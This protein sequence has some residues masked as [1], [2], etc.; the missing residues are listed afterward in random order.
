ML[1]AF[2]IE[3]ELVAGAYAYVVAVTHVGAGPAVVIV[4]AEPVAAEVEA[5]AGEVDG[6]VVVGRRWPWRYELPGEGWGH[7]CLQNRP[8]WQKL[9]ASTIGILILH[10]PG[11]VRRPGGPVPSSPA[12]YRRY[13]PRESGLKD[14]K[15]GGPCSQSRLAS[16]RGGRTLTSSPSSWK[17][18]RG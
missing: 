6:R 12:R 9:A 4:V 11:S 10:S 17:S 18:R 2:E 7:R 16:Q 1:R 14:W 8:N 13:S 15:V 3:Y 5:A